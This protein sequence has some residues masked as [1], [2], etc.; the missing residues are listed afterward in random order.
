MN[1]HIYEFAE[2]VGYDS[3]VLSPTKETMSDTP[4]KLEKFAELIIKECIDKI[5]MHRIPVGNSPAGEI[6][7][8]LTY[9]A[10]L[11][12]RGKIKEHFGVK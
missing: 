4:Q 1:K 2:Q 12:I 3:W 11:A 10:L 8:D 5:E 9:D 6:A 7:Y